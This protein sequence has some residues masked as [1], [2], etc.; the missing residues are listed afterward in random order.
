MFAHLRTIEHI[1]KPLEP[2]QRA[3]LVARVKTFCLSREMAHII[4]TG[5]DGEFQVLA[6]IIADYT[7]QQVWVTKFDD[8]DVGSVSS[9]EIW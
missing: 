7:A 6:R 8:V 5:A 4:A 1:L 2:E 9:F 3:A